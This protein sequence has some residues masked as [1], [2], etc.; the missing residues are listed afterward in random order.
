C[1]PLETGSPLVYEKA[2]E[3][4]RTWRQLHVFREGPAFVVSNLEA[5]TY[6]LEPDYVNI[7]KTSQSTS[8]VIIPAAMDQV[9]ENSV[10][11]PG[12]SSFDVQIESNTGELTYN[13]YVFPTGPTYAQAD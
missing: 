13:I 11:S 10:T 6:T 4:T 7:E 1:E 12:E 2:P 3:G 8:V 5:R 9:P